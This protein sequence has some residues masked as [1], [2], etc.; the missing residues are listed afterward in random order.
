MD[1]FD[2]EDIKSND[3]STLMLVGV[4]GGEGRWWREDPIDNVGDIDADF[5]VCCA[6]R[7]DFEST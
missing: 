6:R 5:V 3:R 7:L 1:L 4:G 2:K